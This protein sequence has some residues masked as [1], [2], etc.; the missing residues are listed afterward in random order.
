VEIV[1]VP[2]RAL[3]NVAGLTKVFAV[4]DGKAVEYR[5]APGVEGPDWMEVPSGTVQAGDMVAVSNLAAL[6]DKASVKAN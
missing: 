5:V 6:V 4:R 1:S 3:Y 2:K